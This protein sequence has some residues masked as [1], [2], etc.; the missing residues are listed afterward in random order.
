MDNVV[1]PRTLDE[2]TVELSNIAAT[3]DRISEL[4]DPST[5]L[6]EASY[7]I[8]KALMFLQSSTYY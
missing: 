8:H 3:V 4:S 2:V 1:W 6:L 5:E 7:A